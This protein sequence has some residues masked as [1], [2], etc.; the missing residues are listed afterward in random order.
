[1]RWHPLI[2]NPRRMREGYCSWFVCLSVCLSVSLSVCYHA[3][4][5]IPRLRVQFHGL[6]GFLQKR[7]VRP[8]W[9]HLLILSF[10]TL[11]ELAIA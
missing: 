4:C 3:S 6:C 2:I 9:R 7:F 8:F 5:Y 11:P 10:L 1:M